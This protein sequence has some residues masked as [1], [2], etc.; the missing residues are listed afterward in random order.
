MARAL[1][2]QISDLH[3]V[4]EGALC[5]GAIDTAGFLARAVAFINDLDP[6]PDAVVVTGDLVNNG[7][8]GE[9]AHLASLLAPLR[10]PLWLLPGNHDDRAELRAAFAQPAA[11]G[12]DSRADFVA[13]AGPLRVIGVDSTIPHR[14]GGTVSPGQLD[15]LGERLAESD[16]DGVPT[17][18]ALHH[19]PFPVGIAHMD[20]MGLEPKAA[21]ALGATIAGAA[22]VEAVVC[23]HLHR[24]II[25]RWAATVAIVAPSV[26][27][28][29]RFDLRPDGPP[30]WDLTPPAL[31]AHAWDGAALVS[32]VVPIGH[33]PGARY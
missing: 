26:A 33:F 6:A 17:I 21:A 29:V 20:A 12:A 31:L 27:H 18:V 16:G 23:G 24:T 32:H 2:V 25:R 28:A 3:I 30:A 22:T 5:V 15:W 9:Y 10:A 4:A 14:P 7:Q 11:A 1:V 8:P 13:Q 19:P